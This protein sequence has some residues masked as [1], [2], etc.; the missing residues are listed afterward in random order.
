MPSAPSTAL[1]TISQQPLISI[2]LVEIRCFCHF[3]LVGAHFSI[4]HDDQ[5]N[6]FFVELLPSGGSSPVL[7]ILFRFVDCQSDGRLEIFPSSYGHWRRCGLVHRCSVGEGP[8]R[9]HVHVHQQHYAV[10][11]NGTEVGKVVHKKP[12]RQILMCT[13]E[14][15]GTNEWPTIPF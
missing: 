6:D 14:E 9:M 15:E 4:T 11:V 8:L 5:T 2:Q 3:E 13:A 10:Q 12:F 1:T 7:A